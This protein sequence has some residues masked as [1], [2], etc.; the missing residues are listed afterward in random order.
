VPPLFALPVP[1]T[2]RPAVEPVLLS[3]IPLAAPLAEM[4][5]KVIPEPPIVVFWTFSAVPVVEEIVLPVPPTVT[6]PPPVALIP[7][8]EV[9][10]I[11][12]PP[13]VKAIV[14]PVFELRV[15]AWFAA[16]LTVLV[17]PLNVVVPAVLP[18]TLMPV[19]PVPV[20][21]PEKVLLPLRPVTSTGRPLPLAIV[22]A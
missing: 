2:V 21:L 10:V 22:P 19:P 16:V 7:L 12:S 6:V 11:A 17:E 14:W 18:E 3:T 5:W 8:P 4:L 13:P 1:V 20:M 9:V 15:T